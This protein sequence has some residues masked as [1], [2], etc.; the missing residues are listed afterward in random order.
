MTPNDLT[1][2][3]YGEPWLIH[4][5]A[6]HT[7]IHLRDGTTFRGNPSL[8]DKVQ[9]RTVMC[10]NVMAGVTDAVLLKMEEAALVR[11]D[12]FRCLV[13]SLVAERDD[14]TTM[15]ALRDWLDENIILPPAEFVLIRGA[16]VNTAIKRTWDWWN[17]TA[18][19]AA[20]ACWALYAW[21]VPKPRDSIDWDEDAFL[22]V[23]EL[24]ALSWRDVSSIPGLRNKENRRALA[25]W[26]KRNG[27]AL[28]ID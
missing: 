16:K 20:S 13:F 19:L 24:L 27:F 4:Q 21:K 8:V 15:M 22:S 28:K 23:G 25:A 14:K 2:R 9:S 10:V 18:G 11:D 7:D 1:D 17:S 3:D 26:L 5:N 6:S 12:P